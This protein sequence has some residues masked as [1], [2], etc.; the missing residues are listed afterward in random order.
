MR[1]G[2]PGLHLTPSTAVDTPLPAG[3]GGACY[4]CFGGHRDCFA[5]PGGRW[6]ATTVTGHRP[7]RGAS[8]CGRAGRGFT[9]PRRL[10]STPLSLRGEGEPATGA[11]G[12]IEIASPLPAVD[13]SQRRSWSHRP[14]RGASRC[15]RAGRG[16]SCG[17]GTR[18]RRRWRRWSGCRRRPRRGWRGRRVRC[19]GGWSRRRCR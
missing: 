17:G 15:G 1:T 10:R 2:W 6:L 13:G 5:S 9:S 8:R 3:R 18:R 12:G 14:S 16:L 7:S 11:L 19:P 4:G